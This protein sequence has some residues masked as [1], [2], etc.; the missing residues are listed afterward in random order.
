MCPL[1]PGRLARCKGNSRRIGMCR[2]LETDKKSDRENRD[3]ITGNPV[4]SRVFVCLFLFLS[5][6]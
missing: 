5:F 4:N 1:Q 6:M 2:D 3:N